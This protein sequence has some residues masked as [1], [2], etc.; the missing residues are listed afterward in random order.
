[1]TIKTYFRQ[2]PNF[3]YVS[4]LPN[5]QIGDYSEVK[6]IF[7]RGKLREDILNEL[8]Y[9]TKYQIR[10][11]DRPDNVAYEIYG[12]SNLDWVVLLSNNILNVQTE[13]PLPQ[14]DFDEYL[15]DKYESYDT[16]YNG[17]HHYETK[18]VKNSKDITIL[19][20]GLNVGPVH[21]VSYYD[22]RLEQQI[23]IA[24]ASVPITNYE[25][26]EKKENDK[27]NIF[28]IKSQY[29]NIIFADMENIMIY[30]QGSSQFKTETLK[31]ADN[32]KIY[33]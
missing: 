10:G 3:E 2:I 33:S 23:D 32:I 17:I 30:R 8:A 25:Y 20:K 18:E 19:P 7:K 13:W 5:A 15:L 31:V 28:V 11:N 22:D 6:N 24:N 16:L 1:M 21:S 14:Q 12:D 9:F 27:R 29:L 26:E 4:R